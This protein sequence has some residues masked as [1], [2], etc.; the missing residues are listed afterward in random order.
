MC[1]K[2][3]KSYKFEC[4]GFEFKNILLHFVSGVFGFL[5]GYFL[6]EKQTFNGLLKVIGIQMIS[7]N[8]NLC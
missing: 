7:L 3:I 8:S 2:D 5:I 1:N 6:I 4:V